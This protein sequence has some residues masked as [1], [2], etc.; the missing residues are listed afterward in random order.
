MWT[1]S[2]TGDELTGVCTPLGAGAC[3][4]YTYTDL[5]ALPVDGPG[6][7]PARVLAVGRVV[8][9]DGGQRGGVDPGPAQR[10]L[11]RRHPRRDRGI[12]RLARHGGHVQRFVDLGGE[13]A[14][15]VDLVVDVIGDRAVVQGRPRR[16]RDPVHA[17]GGR[18]TGSTTQGAPNLYIGTDGKLRGQFWTT[19]GGATPITTAGTVTDRQLAP[20]RAHRCGETTRSCSWTEVRSAR[21]TAGP[22]DH[23]S[24]AYVIG[25]RLEHRLARPHRR[26]QRAVHRPDR[27]RRASTVIRLAESQVDAHYAAR[28]ATSRLATRGG[29]GTVHRHRPDLPAR[30]RPAVHCWPTGT[31]PPGPSARRP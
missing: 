23:L 1:Y 3:T 27:R 13:P 29:A 28:A 11:H 9:S 4:T 12:V 14:D 24:M 16:K 31:A 25:Q 7:P 2:Y 8:G 6:R 21:S 5:V 15:R 30:H 18:P 17:A 22:I 19:T 10:H 20:C 26:H